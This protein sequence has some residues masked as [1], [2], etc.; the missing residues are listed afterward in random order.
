[1]NT[2][3]RITTDRQTKKLNL[4]ASPIARAIALT[5][6]A[7][8]ASGVAHAQS[9]FSPS[10][11]AAKGAAQ[12]NAA[13][14]GRL[15]NGQPAHSLNP[16]QLQSQAARERLQLSIDNLGTAAHAI[17]FQQRLQAQARAAARARPGVPDGLTE[18]GLEVDTNP[19]TA[20]W[21]NA[22][23]PTQ[24]QQD[25][26]TTVTIE[27]TGDKAILNWET[28]NVGRNTT[29]KFEQDASWS[30]LNRVNDPQARPSEIQG[31]IQAEGTV[32]LVNRNG[33]L[34][35]GSSQ[36][37][38]RNLAAAAVNMTDA[39]FSRGLYS[40]TQ[41]AGTNTRHIPSFANDLET[42]ASSFSYGAAT[43]KVIVEQGAEI[44][45]HVPQSVTEG[46]GYVL[47]LGGEV[48]N[49]GEIA[50]A[51]G[52]TMLAA[53]DAFVIRKG[54]STEENQ[55]STTRGNV[56]SALRLADGVDQSGEPVPNPAGGVRN[57]GLIEATTGDITLV[58]HDVRQDG[59]LVSTTSVHTRG[60]IH[61]LNDK[62]DT[63][64]EVTLGAGSVTAIV[65][66]ESATTAL[67]VQREA[68]I[69]DS[70][71]DGD[72]IR[73]RR[74]Q[75]LVQIVSGGDVTFESDSLTLATSGQVFVDAAATSE[76]QAN[77]RI[78]VSGHVGVR[79]AMEANNVEINVQGFEQRDAPVNRDGDNLRNHT[80][81]LDRRD[82]V[83][84]PAGTNGHET[85]RWYTAGGL[86]EVGGYLG[87]TGHGI[88]EWS[89]QGGTVQFSGA[90]LLTRAGSSIN[91]SGGTLDV[92]S[93]YVYQTWLKGIDGN[94]YNASSAPG[95]LLYTGLYRGFESTH[96]R[97]GSGSTDYYH[98]PL[99]APD[100]RI[101][102]GYTV[103][104]DAGRLVVSTQRATLEG[105]IET[106]TFQGNRQIDAREPG[107]D[108][109]QQ[110]QTAAARRGEL[111]IGTWTP[112]YD[113]NDRNLRYTPGAVAEQLVIGAADAVPVESSEEEPA[114]NRIVL[115][116]DW[117]NELEL[118]AL[119]AYATGGVEV[120]EALTVAHGGVVALHA[121]QV[122]INAG[123]TARGGDIALGNIVDVYVSNTTGW[124]ERT[125]VTTP[126]EGYASR[127]VIGAGVTLDARGVWSN[128]QLDP[129]DIG[130]VPYADGGNVTVRSSGDVFVGSGSLID[131][132]SGATLMA[133]DSLH[134]GRGGDI[135]VIANGFPVAGN[136][137]GRL[138]LEG[139]LRGHGVEG[140]GTLHLQTGDAVVIG[141]QTGG[142][143]GF[144][145]EG[146]T[147]LVDL[148]TLE[149]FT[150]DQGAIL[151]LDYTYT[152]TRAAPGEA[153][154]GVPTIVQSQPSTHLT[155]AA[156]WTP[157]RPAAGTYRLI[158]SAGSYQIISNSTPPQLPAGTVIRAINPPQSF[159]SGYVV[160]ADVFPNGIPIEPTIGVIRAGN[161]APVEITFAAGTRI[162]AG[163]QLPRTIAV[164]PLFELDVATFRQ[165][166]SRYEV[167]G[168]GGL[169]VA[170]GAA[171][172]VS[173]PVL[174]VDPATARTVATGSDPAT[175]LSVWEPPLFTEVPREGRLSQRSG[176]DLLLQAGL[177]GQSAMPTLWVGRDADIAVDPGSSIRLAG[178]GQITID[179]RLHA[180]G[181]SIDVL[182]LGYGATAE[183]R[184]ARG[185]DGSIWIGERAVL[186]VAGIASTALDAQGRRYGRVLDGGSIQIGGTYQGDATIAGSVDN[187][188]VIR[189]GALLDASGTSAALDLPSLGQTVVASDGGLIH[190]SSFNGLHVDGQ[191]RAASGGAGAAGGTLSLALET[192]NYATAA[193]PSSRVL[194]H[195]ELQLVREQAPAVLAEDL[196][197]G[198][199]DPALVYG[200]AQLAVDRVEAGG[201]DN[202]SLLVNGVLS[203]EGGVDL[204]LGQSLRLAASNIS[205][206]E[207]SGEGS[208]V[209]L[210]APYVRLA[211]TTRSQRDNH[212]MPRP[213][214]TGALAGQPSIPEG[215]H[216]L[217]E[218]SLLDVIEQLSFG[219]Y[220]YAQPSA[221]SPL[222]ERPAFDLVELRSQG[223]M[224]FLASSVGVGSITGL[225]TNGD[226]ILAASQ[227]YPTM[228]ARVDITA[229]RQGYFDQWGNWRFDLDP[230]RSLRIEQIGNP[231]PRTPFSV[232]GSITLSSAHI[233]Q[234]GILRAPLGTIT[235]GSAGT[236]G[237]STRLVLRP[238]SITSVSAAGLVMP[239]GGTVDGLTY[240]YDGLDAF[241]HGIGS[242]LG[243]VLLRG[244]D[245]EAQEG[246]VID[247]SGG[248][249][250]TG[251]GFLIG[252]GGSTDA[253]LHPLVQMDA[254]GGGFV[255]PGLTTNPVYAIVPGVQ[256]DA[257]PVVAEKGAGD[258]VVGRQIT[259]GDG[260]PGLP[261]GTYTLLPS[262][263]ALLPGAFRV[264][265]NGLASS[266]A[267][268]G[269]TTAM[270]NG[271]YTTAARLG[272][273]STDIVDT[274]T[275]Q[276]IVSSADTLR[277]YSQYKETNYAQF[278]LNWAQR[279]GVPRPQ[280][281]RDARVLL[282]APG[283][284]L[285]MAD[286]VVN[287]NAA[288]HGRAGTVVLQ[289]DRIEILPDGATPSEDFDGIAVHASTLNGIGA[290]T[291]SV[292]A[293]PNS[294]FALMRGYGSTQDA[295]RV[296]FTTPGGSADEI[297]LREGAVLS[298][299]QV[300]LVGSEITVEQG[301][302]IDTLGRGAAPWSSAD[303]YVLSPGDGMLAVS[304]GWLDALP[305]SSASGS[306]YIH[307]GTCAQGASCGGETRLYSEGT[308]T[309]VTQSFLLED[310]V[311]YG[312]RN[313]VLALGGIN[314]GSD[315]AIARAA[316][317]GVLTSGL[318][319]NQDLLDRLLRGDTS[320]GAPALENL[321]LKAADSINFYGSVDL[322]TIDPVS[323]ES[324]LERLVLG[325][326]AVYGYGEA[327]DVARIETDI[328]V[329]N[330]ASSPAGN[331]IA[332]GAGT[333]D[334][335]F[336]VDAR[337]IEFG[338]GPNSQPDS[339]A[340]S[341]RLTVG[342]AAVNLNAS[343]RITANHK[344]TLSV[345]HSQGQ[346]DAATG[347][348]SYSGG[349][350]NINTPLLTGQ[351]G[352]V[353]TITAGGSINAVAPEGSSSPLPDNATLA[354]AL[355]AELSLH[356]GQQLVVDTAVLLPSGK[357]RLTAEEDVTL[358]DGAQLDLAGRKIDF[359]DV[360]KYSWGGEVTLD[361]RGGN[362]V[363]HADSRIDLSAQY[364][365]AGRLTAIALD[366]TVD[367]AGEI[368]GGSSGHYDAGGTQVPFASGYLDIRGRH[369]ADFAGLNA[370]LTEGEV[371]GGRS[372]QLKEGDLVIGDEL[373]A[374]EI[375]V[376]VDNGRLTVNGTI[377]ASGEQAGSIRLAAND[378]VTLA[379]T[380]VLDAS[381][382]VLRKDSYGQVIEAPNR[383][384]IEIDSGDGRL[385]LESGARMDLRV[386]GA[387]ANY[388][389]VAL[390]A[391]RLGGATGNDVDIDA[392]GTVDIAG[393]RSISVNAFHRYDDADVGTDPGVDGRTYQVI[394][395]AY[396]D[397][398]HADSDVFIDNALANG[399][400]MDG[401]LRGLRAY[402]D[403]FHLRPGVEITSNA[404]VN[405]DGDLHVDGD[406]D[407]SGHRYTSVNPHTQR[408]GT[409][410]S[411]EAGALVLRAEGD[412][413]LFGSISDGFDTSR[414]GETPD[415]N[416]WVL[417]AGRM[418][419]G[420]DLIIP[421]G[422][423][424]TLDAG[425]VFK[426]GRTLNYDLP[427]AGLT[428]P[429]GTVLP[430]TM[431]LGQE[432]TL[433]AGTVL[434]ADVRD[435]AGNL[436]HAAGTVLREP[437][438]LAAGMQLG[439]GFRLPAQVQL[440]ATAWPKGA[441]LP[442]NMTLAQPLTLAKGAIVPSE[443]D[444]LLPGGAVMV[445][446]RPT[447]ADGAQ[448]R[449]LAV[450]PMLAA[451]SQSWDIR[452]VAGA[453]PEAADPRLTQPGGTARLRLADTHFGLG[454]EATEVPGTGTPPTYGWGTSE[455]AL[456][457][458][459]DLE[460]WFGV[461]ITAG[462]A[463]SDADVQ[464]LK[465]VG[466]IGESVTE[467][468]DWG[469]GTVVTVI[470]PGTP[471]DLE[472]EPAPVRQ[473]LYS[474]VRTG[475]GDLELISGG[476]FEMTSPYGV[477]TAGTPSVS[478]GSRFDLPRGRL[479][480]GTVLR[481]EGAQYESL[482]DGGADSLY[483]AWYPEHGGNVL[484]SAGG[485]LIGDL[486]GY[487]GNRLD[488]GYGF[489]DT[490]G[491]FE[492][493]AVNTWLWRQGSG[494]VEP[495][496]EA[497]PTAWWVN[498][499]TYVDGPRNGQ[500]DSYGQWLFGN[501]PF[502]VGFTGIGTL[503]GGNLTVQ[504]GGDAGMID[505]RGNAT[506]NGLTQ[507]DSNI[508]TPRSQGLHLAIGSTGRITADGTLVQTGGGDFDLRLGGTL[509]PN[510]Q[511]RR[512]EHDLNST[513]VN[514]RGASRIEAGAIGGLQLRYG[515][516]DHVDTRTGGPYAA[517]RV[518][519]GGG[520]VVVL[521]DSTMRIDTRG[522]LVLGGAGD[523]GRMPLLNST[524]FSYQGTHLEGG[525]WSWFSLWT[526]ATAID[527]FSAGGHLTPT[528]AWAEGSSQEDLRVAVMDRNQ[529]AS[530][531]GYFYPSILRAAAANGSVY[532]GVGT[533]NLRNSYGQTP[534]RVQ[535][536]VTL[537]PSPL[538]AQFTN[539]TGHG[540]LQLLAGQ[541]IF[542]SG[543]TFS[544]STA[545]PWAMTS[546]FRP[547]FV[548]RV[549]ETGGGRSGNEP[550]IVHNSTG[551]IADRNV[552]VGDRTGRSAVAN[553]FNFGSSATSAHAVVGRV[554]SRYYAVEGDIVGLRVG[555]EVLLGF[556]AGAAGSR[557]EASVPVA[558]RAGRDISDSGTQLGR[559]DTV[560][561]G[562][563]G[564][565]G[566]RGNLI[567]HAFGDDVSIVEAGRDIRHS[568]FYVLG[569]GLLEVSAG[570]DLYF[571]NRG[572]L[573]SLGPVVNV[574]PGNRSGGAG[575]S[576]SAGL[577][578]GAHWDAFAARYLDPAN[579]ANPGLPLADQPGKAVYV[580][581]GELTLAQWLQRE[582]GYAGDD[583]GA[584]A[585]LAE[586]QAELDATREAALA[587]GRTAAN[588]SLARE[589][590]LEGQLHLVNWLGER[591]GGRNGL[592]LHFDAA[593]MDAP[594]FFAALPP[595]Q[596][597]AYLRNV[598]YAELKAAGR[599]YNDVGG[600]RFGSYLRGREAIATLFPEQDAAGNALSYEGDLTLFSS[601]LYIDEYVTSNGIF[602]ERPT[603]GLRYITEEEWIAL[604]RPGYGVPFYT[605]QDAGI[606]TNF[607]GDINIL[608]PGG[609]TLV[610]IDGA[611][612]P[613]PQSGLMTQGEGDINIYAQDDILMGQSRI[614][615]T[616]G[617]N[618]LA[619][620]AEGDINAG[621]GAKTT[622]VYTPQRRVYDSVGNV[623]LSPSSP[624]NGAGI[625]T[626]NPI[627]EI[628]PGDIDLIAPLGTIDA[629][630]AGIRVSGNVN[631]AALQV[632][633]AENIQ[634]QGEA[635]GV[636]VLAQVNV[637]ALTDASQAATT[638]VTAAQEVMRR[639][640]A[641]TRESLPSIFS[642]RVL[643][644]GNETSRDDRADTGAT[645]RSNLQSGVQRS[646]DP[647][648][649][650]QI[651][652]LGNNIDPKHWAR[653]T[654]EER[655]RLQ[656]DR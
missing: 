356:A 491:Q 380:A 230:T 549:A 300:F 573:K 336:V 52:Q 478:M 270:R 493:T 68:L 555:N 650:A 54:M 594:A 603:P 331:V 19:L 395:Q 517:G 566:A 536:G 213:T 190:L 72:G 92:Q 123:V 510:A 531:D 480:D 20:G 343:E 5:L 226:L 18:G 524:P 56:V 439:A 465:D 338:Y 41:G 578:E 585:F 569:P 458:W 638:A 509:N 571:A 436:L 402:A 398:K 554:P 545:D 117:L 322:S 204:A 504:A 450:A 157:P 75:S 33:V 275:T 277:R 564:T 472:Y 515:V 394:D 530:D 568:S 287:L 247:L 21:L 627:P 27:Q 185:H 57:S 612:A 105:D 102:N 500:Y 645:S 537:A 601:A 647:S 420:G 84:V 488:Y 317:E 86:L 162:A 516:L 43:G 621:R 326:P 383:A 267:A 590:K 328:L 268:F 251:A 80:I 406:L 45:T 137:G 284:T 456:T 407:L 335:Q 433:A 639:E 132:S 434:G 85:D 479:A 70:D 619:W 237:A 307:I 66:D 100:R 184:N 211:N 347:A 653:L 313:L 76:V 40:D 345:Y 258:P 656:Q 379:G 173:M 115:G 599:E 130:G 225:T 127:A 625:A 635:T 583:S 411:G 229:G 297:V 431:P 576:V 403:A 215:T 44:A 374:R 197:P 31:R 193:S 333:G 486:I 605:V 348:W 424:A 171:V 112:V 498:F 534:L 260:V 219:T 363:Q 649:L 618:I 179:G 390:N 586:K 196:K 572:E 485:D 591:F 469:Y 384:V 7:S 522:D 416:G 106:A 438:V 443:T 354:D 265:L 381:A 419:F 244:D 418:P 250:L 293:M 119:R 429:A 202:L 46:G 154:G 604:G 165:G 643:G 455:S 533:T 178:N 641:A 410:G 89:A 349:D 276:V 360:S 129:T 588:R 281:E 241:Y 292:G 253:R 55:A 521:G 23:D 541:S 91:L 391:P 405:P 553:L 425:T 37:N 98:N 282:L 400:L 311:R 266:V 631:L 371:F 181:G 272:I 366:G 461:V 298:A 414:V 557:Y 156:P 167:V 562:G 367:L 141:G 182:P 570:R 312:T 51:N 316:A 255:L 499:G 144:L 170:S 334:G 261:A 79:I 378:G 369:I 158:T 558:I 404:A 308:I 629:G 342:F 176:A 64:G 648:K 60:T 646:Y 305:S 163:Q 201:F 626:L 341:D 217:I 214:A 321:V 39:Q 114:P 376:S 294:T 49:A 296:G 392:N 340:T 495:G 231:A 386:E 567:A 203:I 149:E 511:L 279:D 280:L 116:G 71:I 352:S 122:D 359:F 552:W 111:V 636:P 426:A 413:V 125:I 263:Y 399:A 200:H 330:G 30:V 501:D 118:G 22:K 121:T 232:F 422:G 432:L 468:N 640:R 236:A 188:I 397:A 150:I 592:G 606:H 2:R 654:E 212:I 527:L 473:Q 412:L 113:R 415:D 136:A 32:F 361:S 337:I 133:D 271:S 216:L 35:D 38:V 596:Q 550:V 475:T 471:P 273:A 582:F 24:V 153:L 290:G 110:S 285:E 289:G 444:V 540:E 278:G 514:L 81:V 560:T 608:T 239:Y 240:T 611:F 358:Q 357:L 103:G 543:L 301:A 29:V 655:R 624:N 53:G 26:R 351:A 551:E 97:W 651:V 148:V 609:R 175:A 408:T 362:V 95:D 238:D 613:G 205:L 453:D 206:Q 314:V 87:I 496:P 344:G 382:S 430:A 615:T 454:Y 547:G 48:H 451:G 73:H 617:G 529:S 497:V 489:A 332:G 487:N 452:L 385:V 652:G 539:V 474:V 492:T 512:N 580:Y 490:R 502:L 620:S 227:I 476:D 159:P 323:G 644:F 370:R 242:G 440:A 637:S 448:G 593:T 128:L 428:L 249:E 320:T 623:T 355:G 467:L 218:S 466:L 74:D 58:G 503:G 306:G 505:I 523:P 12:N 9:A 264:E 442:V 77:A 535:H 519:A 152:R 309:A 375:N 538:D 235:L 67:D 82:L 78:D 577:G 346:Q 589:Y 633:N 286:G 135:T 477:Y 616:F 302:S 191:L 234:G 269:R 138:V 595:E 548:G 364:N 525:G 283:K 579:Q 13:T 396:L 259:I 107:L 324:A 61:L 126:P 145:H 513:F 93:G 4:R 508:H 325:A 457:F 62:T 262:T 169:A 409:Y 25:G 16:A 252:R 177:A 8:G 299:S 542:G 459:N 295:W 134:G 59:T 518:F 310:S 140:G 602:K 143:D 147:S 389:T 584:Q 220:G 597:R 494:S 449:N 598:Y 172:D 42:T 36:V 6:A 228:S 256:P 565:G 642:V 563:G 614:F 574:T 109:Y 417:P 186:D 104:R 532:Y 546:P 446:L 630:E 69:R 441:E 47:L 63:D 304:N 142:S 274:L 353:N 124:E 581:S 632:V 575:I 339:V 460:A 28:F 622:V 329:W 427:V 303:G 17:A 65:L 377:N 161:P 368:A 445:D 484:L 600:R 146:E 233:D 101:E 90:E 94:L 120:N 187:F 520:P 634:V 224:R 556:P 421:H 11:F 388:G 559:N 192:P 221:G 437:L 96:E 83:L 166:F 1:M 210:A 350:L 607:G 246:A 447:G 223:D 245:I 387:N 243:S 561:A 207:G 628:P 183:V 168:V 327:G 3:G 208:R 526:P 544:A 139:E 174:R 15:P 209:R 99:I 470:D 435:G 464:M 248:G 463:V 199:A 164:K 315:A 189:P 401:K 50:T 462:S 507:V 481:E 372:F 365:R 151:P 195:R 423:V 319:L 14:T 194:Q 288:E 318:T 108:G 528:T 10:W 34:F 257:A 291:I 198:E 610:G 393:A 506:L 254:E 222:I 88:G 373:K 587:Q 131:T 160:P 155:L 180:A 483:A 482:V